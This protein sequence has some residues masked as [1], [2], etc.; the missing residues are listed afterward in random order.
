MIRILCE[1]ILRDRQAAI[2][3]FRDEFHRGIRQIVGD[4]VGPA[5]VQH[6]FRRL[7]RSLAL[8]PRRSLRSQSLH[9]VDRRR[10]GLFARFEGFEGLYDLDA[11]EL[12]R[13]KAQ[14][15]FP[16]ENR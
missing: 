11:G 16:P 4:D 1:G 6:G 15:S 5:G 7:R 14:G 13:E 12:L 10:I 3:A 2:H 9:G 8:R